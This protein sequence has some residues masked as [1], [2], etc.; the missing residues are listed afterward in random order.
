MAGVGS[1]PR[2]LAGCPPWLRARGD[3]GLD[4]AAELAEEDAAEEAPPA[5]DGGDSAV[6]SGRATGA[7]LAESSLSAESAP[8]GAAVTWIS[9]S[10]SSLCTTIGFVGGG[11][12]VDGPT[13]E[14]P[15]GD[16][17]RL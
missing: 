3:G 4:E 12:L 1:S 10:R 16:G 13:A 17:V 5:D 15:A 8:A 2:P 7:Q 11:G 6:E 14:A 9:L